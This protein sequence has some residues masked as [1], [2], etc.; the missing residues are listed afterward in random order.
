MKYLKE[1]KCT[2]LDIVKLPDGDF[3]FL[4]IDTSIF[5]THSILELIKMIRGG[6]IYLLPLL[7]FL[8]TY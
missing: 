1:K 7:L 8:D 4:E 5:N 3:E 6:R 2:L